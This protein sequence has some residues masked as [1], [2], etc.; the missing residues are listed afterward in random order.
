MDWTC[1]QFSLSLIPGVRN[2]VVNAILAPLTAKSSVLVQKQNPLGQS[3][4]ALINAR[5]LPILSQV[6]DSYFDRQIR[7]RNNSQSEKRGSRQECGAEIDALGATC[8]FAF[9]TFSQAI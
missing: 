6:V 7:S 9:G 3:S 5:S 2:E 4:A 8:F 1:V